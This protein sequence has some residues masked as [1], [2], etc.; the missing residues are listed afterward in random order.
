MYTGT[1]RPVAQIYRSRSRYQYRSMKSGQSPSLNNHNVKLTEA[2]SL[3]LDVDGVIVRDEQLLAHVA[4]NCVKF[5]HSMLP[6]GTTWKEAVDVN[7]SW[8]KSYGHTLRGMYNTYDINRN[9]F[10]EVTARFNDIVYDDDTLQWLDTYLKS[11]A[12]VNDNKRIGAIC[13][14]CYDNGIPVFLFSNAPHTWCMPVANQFERMFSNERQLI[15]E[16]LTPDHHV[17]TAGM[18]KPDPTLYDRVEKYIAS[19]LLDTNQKYGDNDKNKGNDE[20]ATTKS[21]IFVDDSI[22]NL[23]PLINSPLWKTILYPTNKIYTIEHIEGVLGIDH[24]HDRRIRKVLL[25]G[26]PFVNIHTVKML[27]Q[28]CIPSLSDTDA[29][30]VAHSSTLSH[31]TVVV[32]ECS[33][34]NAHTY[35]QRLVENGLIASIV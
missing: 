5:V 9:K 13:N 25:H 22:I 8:Y 7:K 17:F 20:T 29:S 2:T 16:V 18:Y 23:I 28:V 1:V 26:G 6:P 34:E 10:H 31:Q 33:E 15:T 27:L 11:D 21:L 12:F 3:M 24:D 32:V 4:E 14:A 19:T 35:C 30:R